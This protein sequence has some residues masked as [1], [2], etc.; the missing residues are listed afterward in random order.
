MKYHEV[1]GRCK[2]VRGGDPSLRV[3]GVRARGPGLSA[4]IIQLRLIQWPV[5]N[6]TK[7]VGTTNRIKSI[8]EIVSF[9]F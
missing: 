5:C 9:A 1:A 3:D 6:V 8:A 2:E 7:R 4:H